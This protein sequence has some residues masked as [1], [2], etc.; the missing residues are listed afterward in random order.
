MNQVDNIDFTQLEKLSDQS[1]TLFYSF[2]YNGALDINYISSNIAAVLG[3][4]SES[5]TSDSEAWLNRI[6][7]DDKEELINFYK[8]DSSDS[9]KEITTRIKHKDGHY[10]WLRH[11][12]NTS[13]DEKYQIASAVDITELKQKALK[14]KEKE[15]ESEESL[16][17]KESLLSEIHHR[18][19]NNLAIMSGLLEMQ[20]FN[21][22][23]EHLLQ[24]LEENQ[25]RIK[26]M[27]RV[28]EKLYES[29]SFYDIPIAEYVDDLL[30]TISEFVKQPD[31]E[32]T[33]V[34]EV[35]DISLNISQAVPFGIVLNEL[36]SNCYRYAFEHKKEGKIKVEL[37]QEEDSIILDITDNG[38]G[39]PDEFEAMSASSTAM[40]LVD[41]LVPQLNGTFEAKSDDSGTNFT[42]TFDIED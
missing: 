8:D 12:L 14:R 39:L 5:F 22:E 2:N 23:D 3:Y 11:E 16:K 28:H 35:E 29:H 17:E 10:Q 19:K 13:T 33:V 31:K 7:P 20:A 37:F 24:R 15:D 27:G 18:V 42:V 1:S 34:K 26:A 30:N 25:M 38:Q 36:V 4:E 6:H 40:T 9:P 41:T 21:A 32:I